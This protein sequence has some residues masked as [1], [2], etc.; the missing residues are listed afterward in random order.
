LKSAA[1]SI[2]YDRE[3]GFVHLA[4]DAPW[5]LLDVNGV[6]LKNGSGREIDMRSLRRGIYLVRS[7]NRSLRLSK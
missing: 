2:T 1:P 5:S 6:V 3:N 4:V 7:G